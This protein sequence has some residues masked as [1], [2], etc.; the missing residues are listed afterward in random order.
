MKVFS[1]VQGEILKA[2]KKNQLVSAG[3]GSGK[4]TIMIEKI[5]GLLLN[6]KVDIDNL[7]VVTFTVLAAQEMKERLI[8]KLKEVVVTA[9]DSNKQEILTIIEKIETA[10]I[11]TI[12]GF[13]S[14]TIKK[15]FYDLEISPNIEIISD[16]TRDYYLTR[17]M[18]KTFDD[19]TKQGDKLNLI[20]DLFGGNRRNLDAIESLIL[21]A[22]Y[23]IINI[24]D[25]YG[26][27]DECIDEYRDSVK[28]ERVLNEYVCNMVSRVR[29]IIIEEYSSL[30][31]GVK[32]KIS[33]LLEAFDHFN[34]KVSLKTN[35]KVLMSLEAVRFTPTEYKENI[36]LKNTF[37]QIGEIFEIKNNLIKNQINENYEEKNEKIINYLT[38][39]ID[40]LKNFIKNYNKIKEK[41][42]LID[43]NDLNRLML[44]L[45]DNKNIQQELQE[46]YKYIF[47][48]EYQD[49]NHL[50]DSLMKKLTGPNTT[51]FM[52]GDV[53]QSIYGFRGSSP[54]WFLGK[55]NTMKKNIE[56]EDVFDMN[57]NFR[58]SPT[59][60][61]FINQIF[62]KLMTVGVADIDYKNDCEIEPKRDDILDEKVKIML[63][64]EEKEA[65]F[66]Q[67]Y[68]SVK[69]HKQVKN[70]TTKDKEALL[71]LK[72]ITELIGK[73]FYDANAKQNRKLTYKDIAILT[74]SDKDE[75]SEI[76]TGVLKAHHVP[77]NVNNKLE[78]DS[79]EAIKLILSILKCVTGVADDVDYLAMMLSLTDLTIDDIVKI[80]DKNFTFY[81]NLRQYI[82]KNA[83]N[84]EKDEIFEKITFGFDLLN[85]LHYA[86]CVKTNKELI[87]YVLNDL[88]LKYY[89]LQKEGGQ[90]ELQLVEEYLSKLSSVEDSLGLAEFVE[91][92]ETNVNSSGDFVS[93]DNEDSVTLQTIHK[94]KGLEYPV[95]ILFNSSKMFA[96]H[97]DNDAINFNANL[98]F[99]LDYFD[100]VNRVKMD[101]LTK[102]AIKIANNQ[103]GYKEELRL[104][105]VA[106]TRAKN[107]LYITGSIANKDFSDINKTSYTNMLLS[108]FA[109]EITD[110]GLEKENF[111]IEFVEDIS[112]G[113]EKENSIDDNFE[114][115]GLDFV[116]PNQN[117]FSIPFKNSVTGINSEQSQT[118]GYKIK[119][120]INSSSQ[121]EVDDRVKTG[122][123]YHSALEAI[124]FTKPYQQTTDLEGVDYSKIKLAY[125]KLSP[126]CNGAIDIK[127]EADFMMLIPYN[128]VVE[129]DIE[130]KILI[131]GIVDLLIEKEN[132]IV[133]VD[134]KFSRLDAETLKEK[135]QEQLRLYKIALE[136][137]YNKPV[138]ETYIYSINSGELI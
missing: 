134:Y 40:L 36:N 126:L 53:K 116:Y 73:E 55:Y 106:L 31:S 90:K 10:S 58:S 91:L 47:I 83:Q 128:K 133:L 27:L 28:S 32:G 70:I 129:S 61:K 57:V 44:K 84:D 119:N 9:D 124:D 94:S 56:S 101:S 125:E 1:G 112:V 52:V 123:N 79:S 104:L 17:A 105:Y 109:D 20:L 65:D 127:K 86:S 2:D 60:L 33:S 24:E 45:L 102:F 42:N 107:K 80:R 23:N 5:A 72:I 137:A 122:V 13:A 15:Y 46:K 12:D 138:E 110:E 68:Y 82:D 25:Y 30:T 6:D 59:I 111:K 16:T 41:H 38:I 92:V 95:V 132:S 117:K 77:F 64:Q 120:I 49:V 39:F 96:Y 4:T 118:S 21:S 108:C 93:V 19:Y 89:I 136:S 7:L 100:I 114:I 87:S 51:V 50:Q 62:S 85:K 37:S 26:F 78:V 48:D 81:E 29:S 14:K 99:G 11:D 67:G 63:V 75:S 66:D 130:D 97:R 54:E 121:Y 3:A 115:V 35:L 98:G 76:L 8:N 18:K 69:D 135:Y 74:H 22:Y 43:F 131:Q 71:V 103:K 113:D 88:K 34:D